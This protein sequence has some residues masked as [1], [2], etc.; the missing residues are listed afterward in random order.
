MVDSSVVSTELDLNLPDEPPTLSV[1]LDRKGMAWQR[2]KDYWH[3]VITYD[4]LSWQDLVVKRGPVRVLPTDS[5]LTDQLPPI[6]Y[7]SPIDSTVRLRPEDDI[8][9]WNFDIAM[10]RH[11]IVWQR[12]PDTVLWY[13]TM[14]WLPPIQYENLLNEHGPLIELS[15]VPPHH[16]PEEVVTLLRHVLA[17]KAFDRWASTPIQLLNDQTPYEAIESGNTEDVVELVRTYLD[18]S[19]S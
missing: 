17:A 9:T 6:D 13:A 15:P 11:G 3:P 12:R 18:P 5:S 14:S 1:V 8:D 16:L 7:G 4:R 2:I 10:D 19:C